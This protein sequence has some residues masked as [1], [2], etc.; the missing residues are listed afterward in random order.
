METFTVETSLKA[1]IAWPD[2]YFSP[3]YGRACEIAEC[4]T[5]EC[6]KFRD[7]LC[8]YLVK[9]SDA[10]ERYAVSPYGYSGLYYE[11][12]SSLNE[13]VDT[14]ESLCRDK[15][16]NRV[17]LRQSP[18]IAQI[19]HTSINKRIHLVSKKT[20]FSIDLSKFATVGDYVDFLKSN[21]RSNAVRKIK[22][23]VKLNFQAVMSNFKQEDIADFL[24][25]YT[26]AMVRLNAQE[27]YF[28]NEKYFKALIECGNVLY[29]RVVTA[30]MVQARAL[31]LTHGDKMHY[32]LCAQEEHCINGAI[33]FLHYK[34][35]DYALLQ[36][37]KRYHLGGGL[38]DGDSL[39]SFKK[40]I[41]NDSHEY[42]VLKLPLD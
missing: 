30:G 24:Q 13:F 7:V 21:G 28:Y 12:E 14:F 20:T 40:S 23:A 32:H 35:V 6:C 27:V 36:K 11:D 31:I 3:A 37:I 10:G 29:V 33:N 8:V 22:K 4:G 38:Q 15:K 18:L 34:L 9:H 25:C 17:I 16:C 42:C 41:A 2:V 26:N 39:F 1:N 19:G 5:W